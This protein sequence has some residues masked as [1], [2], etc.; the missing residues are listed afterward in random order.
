[1]SNFGQ[2]VPTGEPARIATPLPGDPR[3]SRLSLNQR[4]T[5]R[6]SLAEAVAGALAAGIP[7]IGLWREPVA[8]HGLAASVDL[9]AASGL[10]VSSLCR[11]G[12]F[13]DP[14]TLASALDDN[15]AALD[16]AAALGARALVIVAGGLAVGDRDIRGARERTVEA[17]G[18]L[19][20]RAHDR[21]VALAIEAMHPIFAADRGVFSTLA[22]CLD[23]AEA[24]DP[25]DVGV[26]V[27]TFHTWWDPDLLV[28]IARAAGRILS[29]QVSDWI[30]P[31]PADTLLSRG[32]MGDGHIDYAPITRAVSDAGYR[33]DVEVEIFNAEIW[34]A[35]GGDITATLT[36][37]YAELIAPWL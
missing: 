2:D 27:D 23:I 30:T 19:V 17:I 20:E 25:A 10:R 7:S 12:Y 14:A 1:V 21:G 4:T 36:R 26:V 32:M 11:G 29:Y 6:W 31:L 33:G 28:Q 13:T 3:L 24:F 8:E 35:D 34:A 9:I 37:R 22:Q 15:Y 5:A 16:E 18:V